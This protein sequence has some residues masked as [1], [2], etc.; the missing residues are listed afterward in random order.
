MIPLFSGVT[1]EGSLCLVPVS[2]NHYN[3]TWVT[4][5]QPHLTEEAG[6]GKVRGVAGER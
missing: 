5:V 3:K 6:G 4:P 1:A 2:F